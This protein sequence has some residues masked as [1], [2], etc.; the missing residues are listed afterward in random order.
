MSPRIEGNT[1]HALGEDPDLGPK[2]TSTSRESVQEEKR[3]PLPA[4]LDV[5]L[6]FV[7]V[8][9]RSMY[10]GDP[11]DPALDLG[12]TSGMTAATADGSFAGTP[13]GRAAKAVR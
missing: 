5:K 8:T 6:D 10:T 12:K 1:T 3:E 4:A 9:H 7:P 2:V 13:L 11:A